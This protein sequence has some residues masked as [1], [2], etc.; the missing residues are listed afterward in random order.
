MLKP[1]SF[2]SIILILFLALPKAKVLINGLQV[3]FL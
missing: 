1:I 2:V 3:H